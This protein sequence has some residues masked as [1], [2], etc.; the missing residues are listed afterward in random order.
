LSKLK[1]DVRR[2]ITRIRWFVWPVRIRI[3][4]DPSLKILED[5]KLFRDIRIGDTTYR[6]AHDTGGRTINYVFSLLPKDAFVGKDV[7][8][9]G[10]AAGAACFEAIARGSRR[11]VAVEIS[12]RSLRGGLFIKRREHIQN[13]KFVSQDFFAFLRGRK[14]Q[15]DVIFVLNVLHHLANPFPMLRRICR[16]ARKHVIIEVPDDLSVEHY[17]QYGSEMMDVEGARR[18]AGPEDFSQFLAMYDFVLQAKRPSD[19]NAKFFRGQ[20]SRRTVYVYERRIN[21]RSKSYDERLS[22]MQIYR[23]ARDESYRRARADAANIDIFQGD[24][25]SDVLGRTLGDTWTEGL[26][27]A[28]VVGPRCSGKTYWIENGEP[29]TRPTYHQKVFK[30]SNNNNEDGLYRHLNPKPGHGGQIAEALISTLDDEDTH[31]TVAALANAIADRPVVCLFLNVNFD[32]HFD[33]LYEREL[34][35]AGM[36]HADVNPDEFEISLRFDCLRFI[37]MLQKKTCQYRVLT[38]TS[39]K[40]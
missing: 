22:E 20:H 3:S 15:F 13:V 9:V 14:Y 2:A 37:Q 8:D 36:A 17:G 38:Y 27:N 25:P 29:N 12:E 6:G 16:T 7:L 26:V 24:M 39:T 28:L 35:L 4:D 31:C 1:D 19:S 21:Q 23:Q 10:S 40:H 30:F 32:D 11:A 34:V 33:R 18:A 5:V